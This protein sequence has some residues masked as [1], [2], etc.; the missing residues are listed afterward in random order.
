[1]NAD[2][3]QQLLDIQG[4]EPLLELLRADLSL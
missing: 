3:R 1:M 2:F 4:V